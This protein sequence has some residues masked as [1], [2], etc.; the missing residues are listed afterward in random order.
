MFWRFKIQE[1]N[2]DRFGRT[3]EEAR[4]EHAKW[5]IDTLRN[6]VQDEQPM[7]DLFDKCV[8]WIT[9]PDEF[10][11]YLAGDAAFNAYTEIKTCLEEFK[12]HCS[13]EEIAGIEGWMNRNI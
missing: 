12:G 13:P 2:R 3:L 9:C 1:N 11:L 4:K 6:N 10:R 8:T 7:Q 5:C